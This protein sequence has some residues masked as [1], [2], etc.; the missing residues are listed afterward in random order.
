MLA[1]AATILGGADAAQAARIAEPVQPIGI[2]G[3]TTRPACLN[4]FA[5]FIRTDLLGSAGVSEG[6]T[7][8]HGSAALRAELDATARGAD[9]VPAAVICSPTFAGL[10]GAITGTTSALLHRTRVGPGWRELGAS[11]LGDNALE[12]GDSLTVPAVDDAAELRLAVV[13]AAGQPAAPITLTDL[14][15]GPSQV[16]VAQDAR[17]LVAR[18]VRADGSTA[19][20]IAQAAREPALDPGISGTA[21][22]WTVTSHH[23]PGTTLLVTAYARGLTR[24]QFPQ[25][26]LRSGTAAAVR[27]SLRIRKGLFRR[28]TVSLTMIAT[29]RPAHLLR[30]TRCKVRLARR[31]RPQSI[32]CA[33]YPLS[34][35]VAEAYQ[36]AF[37]PNPTTIGALHDFRAALQAVGSGGNLTTIRWSRSGPVPRRRPL[38]RAARAATPSRTRARLATPALAVVPFGRS[39]DM[40]RIGGWHLNPLQADVNGDGLPDFWTD[41]FAAR[42]ERSPSAALVGYVYTSSPSGLTPHRVDAPSLPIDGYIDDSEVGAIAD[43]TGDGIGEL[44]VDLGDRHAVIPGS[45]GW[46]GTTTPIVAPSATAPGPDQTVVEPGGSSPGMAYAA[47]DDVTGDGLRELGVTEDAGGWFAVASGSIRRGGV[48]SVPSV[49]GPVHAPAV[50]LG[51]VTQSNA[52]LAPQVEPTT[53]VIAGQA[54]GL[55]WLRVATDAA[56]T[57]RLAITVR[58]AAGR[59]VAPTVDLATPGNAHLLDYDRPTGDL[60]LRSI[61]PSCSRGPFGRCAQTLLRVARSG[62]VRQ[63]VRIAAEASSRL[64]AATARFMGDGPDSD[65]AAEI[66]LLGGPRNV[67]LVPSGAAGRIA[68]DSLAQTRLAALDPWSRDALPLARLLPV[69]APDGSRRV[70]VGLTTSTGLGDRYLWPGATPAE[71]V[72]K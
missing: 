51:E 39:A 25:R 29:N 69:V 7:E 71:L 12:P 21:R 14:A 45:A 36:G 1:A 28:R 47:L 13:R 42:P 55:R 22:R 9:L 61:T 27:S 4:P 40:V 35:A 18:I 43:I 11:L 64:E 62:V 31:G 32:R 24:D 48:T 33:D 66:V 67:A 63:S 8:G 20:Q 16:T 56:R 72:W 70:T 30:L 37:A 2:L 38:L 41:E 58:D 57:G 23:R 19:E 5:P 44:I 52:G 65:S 50:I 53:M 6:L 59:A 34:R 46:T 26:L 15:P 68:V 3:D 10:P 17:G 54:V 49:A 60:L